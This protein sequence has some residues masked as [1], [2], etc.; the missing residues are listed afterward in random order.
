VDALTGLPVLIAFLIIGIN[1]SISIET[2]KRFS[3]YFQIFMIFGYK[4]M[5]N[6]ELRMVISSRGVIFLNICYILS[7]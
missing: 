7:P 3:I 1:V 4:K 6:S 2:N 5:K